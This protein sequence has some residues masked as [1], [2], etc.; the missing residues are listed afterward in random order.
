MQKVRFSATF[1]EIQKKEEYLI[2]DRPVA[3]KISQKTLCPKSG[4]IMS[5]S[6]IFQKSSSREHSGTLKN[7]KNKNFLFYIKPLN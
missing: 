7:I 2:N 6:L 1:T 3:P 5:P 4:H